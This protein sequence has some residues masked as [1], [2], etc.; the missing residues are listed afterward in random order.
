MD[1]AASPEPHPVMSREPTAIELLALGG[2]VMSGSLLQT[3]IEMTPA[4]P[5]WWPQFERDF[6]EYVRLA[7]P[8][9]QTVTR[10]ALHDA[11][12]GRPRA[13]LVSD[14]AAAAAAWA[15]KSATSRFA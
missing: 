11:R 10:V 4:E 6:A 14:R 2:F 8:R 5:T 13:R 9:E 12:S 15:S 1:A 7:A 3:E